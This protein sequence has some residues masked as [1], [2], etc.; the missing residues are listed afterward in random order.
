MFQAQK[1]KQTSTQTSY[2]Q[3]EYI[4]FIDKQL[5]YQSLAYIGLDHAKR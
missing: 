4:L 3:Y 5:G 2:K 1:Y